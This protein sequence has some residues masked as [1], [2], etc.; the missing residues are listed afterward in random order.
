M[1][2]DYSSLGMRARILALPF[3]ILLGIS[4]ASLAFA[5]DTTPPSVTGLVLSPTSVDVTTGPKS[6]LVT[7]TATDDLSGVKFVTVTFTSP[8]VSQTQFAFYPS[9]AVRRRT[10]HSLATP[11][12]RSTRITEHGTSPAS[13]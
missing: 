7:M 6:V 3:L 11:P 5:D 10:E 4:T 1:N 13:S 2:R 9:A 12:F 8:H